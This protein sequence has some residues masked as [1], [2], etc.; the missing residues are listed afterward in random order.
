MISESFRPEAQFSAIFEKK[1]VDGCSGA[2]DIANTNEMLE[3]NENANAKDLPEKNPDERESKRYSNTY[4]HTA[5]T[6]SY[7]Q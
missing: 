3:E 1:I 2:P 7:N 4:V 5:K 6:C